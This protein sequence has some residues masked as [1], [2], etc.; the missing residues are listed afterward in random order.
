[1]THKESLVRRQHLNVAGH[2]WRCDGVGMSR[3]RRHDCESH[4]QSTDARDEQDAPRGLLT[5]LVAVLHNS[6]PFFQMSFLFVHSYLSS[7]QENRRRTSGS[8][9]SGVNVE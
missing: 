2:G 1:M 9:K 7:S 6:I 5:L 4:D 8:H 3:L